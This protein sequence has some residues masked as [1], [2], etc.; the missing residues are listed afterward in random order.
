MQSL[1]SHKSKNNGMYWN[2]EISE[3]IFSDFCAINHKIE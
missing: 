3:G 1:S 2:V